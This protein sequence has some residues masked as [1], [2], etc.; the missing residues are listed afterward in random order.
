MPGQ[1]GNLTS[2]ITL[3]SKLAIN[4]ARFEA[5]KLG[6][7]SKAETGLHAE[8]QFILIYGRPLKFPVLIIIFI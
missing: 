8:T 7:S 5:R 2:L 1:C 3:Y 4:I 6:E